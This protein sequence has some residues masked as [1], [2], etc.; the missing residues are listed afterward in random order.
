MDENPRSWAEKIPKVLWTYMMTIKTANGYTPFSL[1]FGLEAV[2]PCELVWPSA[3]ITTY[4]EKDNED[5]QLSKNLDIIK[6][7]REEAKIKEAAYRRKI[8]RVFNKRL[9]NAKLAPGDLVLRN[10]HLTM[11]EQNK[12]K[13]SQNWEGPGPYIIKEEWKTGT[14]KLVKEDGIAV[15]RT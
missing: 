9:R 1:A 15:S 14:F 3:R 7:I 11:T 10:S 13:L 6:N 2:A 5:N 8:E 12:G 4:D